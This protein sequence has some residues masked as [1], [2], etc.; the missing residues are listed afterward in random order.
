M[1]AA[2]HEGAIRYL[3]EKG[4]WGEAHA[5]FQQ[6]TVKRQQTLQA[7]WKDMMAKESQAKSA[8]PEALWKLWEPRRAEVLKSL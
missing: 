8:A 5:T 4:I 3:K 7:A 1:D 6:R 2:F